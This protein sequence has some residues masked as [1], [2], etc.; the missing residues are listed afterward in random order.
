MIGLLLAGLHVST[1]SAGTCLAAVRALADAH[2]IAI[3]P[4]NA[5]KP[6]AGNGVT[7]KELSESGGVIEPPKV[8]DPAVIEP[9]GGVRYGMP[10]MP[11]HGGKEPRGEAVSPL[12]PEKLALLESILLAARSEALQGDEDDCYRQFRKAQDLAGEQSGR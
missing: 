11:E 4:P 1:A 6:D 2:G 3:D 7:S 5:P 12:G 8:D 10:T 9:P